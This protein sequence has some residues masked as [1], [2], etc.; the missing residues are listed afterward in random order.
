MVLS[1][2]HKRDDFLIEVLK[3]YE[4]DSGWDMI[5][6]DLEETNFTQLKD[7]DLIALLGQFNIKAL[8]LSAF[9]KFSAR[10]RKL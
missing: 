8:Y 2:V 10:H 3:F 6:D 7:T 1:P 5:G 4:G 9:Q